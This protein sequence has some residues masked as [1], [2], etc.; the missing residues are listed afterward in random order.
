M[1]ATA[2]ARL[3]ALSLATIGPGLQV[4][5][6]TWARLWV[7]RLPTGGKTLP[8]LQEDYR[9]LWESFPISEPEEIE[10]LLRQYA[11][12]MRLKGDRVTVTQDR[13][14]AHVMT[15][16]DY[17]RLGLAEPPVLAAGDTLDDLEGIAEQAGLRDLRLSKSMAIYS[18]SHAVLGVEFPTIT[19]EF[20]KYL[21]GRLANG[22]LNRSDNLLSLDLMIWEHSRWI[23]QI[24]RDHK[25][26]ADDA[27]VELD[28]AEYEAAEVSGYPVDD[29]LDD[30]DDD[31]MAVRQRRQRYH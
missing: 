23:A 11:R 10:P 27:P 16:K 19:G 30:A 3:K 26:T 1:D 28:L 7:D 31:A 9:E 29:K 2:A 18:I 24:I 15:Q 5:A 6:A 12:A 22:L 8:S 25:A 21:C 14:L 20:P 13:F 17:P 4:L